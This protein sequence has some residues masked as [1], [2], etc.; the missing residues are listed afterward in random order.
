MNTSPCK[1]PP[2]MLLASA[3]DPMETSLSV[4]PVAAWNAGPICPCIRS[5][6]DPAESTSTGP[7]G[8]APVPALE[9]GR[10]A[11]GEGHSDRQ[12][13][14]AEQCSLL[15]RH[16]FKVTDAQ[17]ICDEVTLY[18]RWIRRIFHQKIADASEQCSRSP[19]GRPPGR[20]RRNRRS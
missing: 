8:L 11:R 18:T 19:A 13:A 6:S 14:E 16:R 4:Y 10:A 15:E 17:R 9:L 1:V 12:A 3:V 20:A 5:W 2:L 7:D